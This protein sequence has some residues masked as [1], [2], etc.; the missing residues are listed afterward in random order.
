[1]GEAQSGQTASGSRRASESELMDMPHREHVNHG[2]H[3][4]PGGAKATLDPG[5]AIDPVCGMTVDITTAK[6]KHSFGGSTWYFCS[7]H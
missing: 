3:G 6:H 4:H 5:T 1:M 7:K 2:H